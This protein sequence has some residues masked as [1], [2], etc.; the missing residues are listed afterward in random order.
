MSAGINSGGGKMDKS[1]QAAN[2]QLAHITGDEKS[3]QA[4]K[5]CFK[6]LCDEITNRNFY[7]GKDME[8]NREEGE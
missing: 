4:N 5:L 8:K 7:T 6:I 1:I 3:R 2:K